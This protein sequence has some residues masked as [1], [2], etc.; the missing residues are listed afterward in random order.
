MIETIKGAIVKVLRT[1]LVSGSNTFKITIIKNIFYFTIT[2][3]LIE[4]ANTTFQM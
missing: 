3:M 2:I 4:D 1:T